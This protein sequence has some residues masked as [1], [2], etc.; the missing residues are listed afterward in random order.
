MVTAIRSDKMIAP[1]SIL[2]V[3]PAPILSDWERIST[4]TSV[5]ESVLGKIANHP[6]RESM[7]AHSNQGQNFHIRKVRVN[8][9]AEGKS[10]SAFRHSLELQ[11][12]VNHCQLDGKALLTVRGGS[13][14]TMILP[15][16]R[17]GPTQTPKP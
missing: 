6:R 12:W 5:T 11:L 13:I 9:R 7:S 3:P 2:R 8:N 15:S 16:I 10:P 14:S 1:R 4:D 17:R